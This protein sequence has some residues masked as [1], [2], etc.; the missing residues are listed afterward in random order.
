MNKKKNYKE[1]LKKT[2]GLIIFLVIL[3]FVF[4]RVTYLFR[5]TGEERNT[6]AGFKSEDT[7]LDVVFISGSAVY[8]YWEPYS[9]FRDFGFT[10]YDLATSACVMEN[11]LPYL[12]YSEKY[13]HPKLYVIELRALHYFGNLDWGAAGFRNASDSL[14]I[15]FLPRYHAINEYLRNRD[16]V[17]GYED[18]LSFYFDIAKYHTNYENLKSEESWKLINNTKSSPDKGFRTGDQWLYME[19]PVKFQSDRRN[20]L[21]PRAQMLLEEILAYCDEKELK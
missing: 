19:R 16:F 2:A 11:Y 15:T 20:E 10:S 13:Q 18:K 6:V 5:N 7:D 8:R 21:E 17:S 1:K 3:S 4:S 9:A 14:D 12:K